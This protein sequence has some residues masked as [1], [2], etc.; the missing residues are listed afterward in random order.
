ME[1]ETPQMNQEEKPGVENAEQA[2]PE[3]SVGEPEKKSA[4]P[5]FGIVIIVVLLILAGFY[6]WGTLNDSMSPAE[7]AA[8][9]DTA[10]ESL[11]TQSTSDE[12]SDIEADLDATSLDDL[13]QELGDID[14]EL[15]F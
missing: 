6:F 3:M 2:A 8:E 9:A 5:V 1:N 12:I 15:D 13:D 7:I 4:G 10:L 11:E 14:L